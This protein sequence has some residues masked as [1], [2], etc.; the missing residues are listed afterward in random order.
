MAPIAPS[1]SKPVSSPRRRSSGG[2]NWPP[3]RSPCYWS[4][5]PGGDHGPAAAVRLA[6]QPA[7]HPIPHRRR[8]L[9]GNTTRSL[10]LGRVDA[11]PRAAARPAGPASPVRVR[12]RARPE[13]AR[14]RR[15]RSSAGAP[16]CAQSCCT[17]PS[18]DR[19]PSSP[20]TSSGNSPRH[21][22]TVATPGPLSAPAQAARLVARPDAVTEVTFNYLGTVEATTDGQLLHTTVLPTGQPSRPE[23]RAADTFGHHRHRQHDDG[24]LRLRPRPVP[25]RRSRRGR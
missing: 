3:R 18:A 11:G 17:F 12:R 23:Q 4:C 14:A 7:R 20:P 2:S 24:H 19:W 15:A 5:R 6:A 8:A 10:L 25:P 13:P 1:S 22:T 21:P 16:T 9:T